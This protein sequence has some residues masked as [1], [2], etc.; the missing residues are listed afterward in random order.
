MKQI[1]FLLLPTNFLLEDETLEEIFRERNNYYT[2]Q[3][4]KFNFWISKDCSLLFNQF[5]NKSL[6][7]TNFYLKN[8]N[9]I[10][11]LNNCFSVIYSDDIIFINWLKLR[12][13]YCETIL[14]LF[15]NNNL[16]INYKIENNLLYDYVTFPKGYFGKIEYVLFS[17]LLLNNFNFIDNMI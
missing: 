7:K 10:K 5:L 15:R 13:G 12:I 11:S 6:E 4:K 1:Q 14:N 3:N 2:S 8:K 9:K 16:N 17:K